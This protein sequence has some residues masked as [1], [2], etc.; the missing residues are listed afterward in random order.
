MA[1]TILQTVVAVLFDMAA[2]YQIFMIYR[3]FFS[4]S[5]KLSARRGLAIGAIVLG[6]I[7][8]NLYFEMAWDVMWAMLLVVL[9]FG[10]RKLWESIL[11]VPAL[12]VYTVVGVIPSIML[13]NVI[14]VTP[15]M[16]IGWGGVKWIDVVAEL[17][18]CALVTFLWRFARKHKISLLLRPL[19]VAGFVLFF[20]FE[21]F[22]L[23]VIAVI[24]AYYV[25]WD[26]LALNGCCIFFFA[27]AMGAYL[28]HLVTLRRVRRLDALVKQ[29]ENYINFQ[30]AYLEKYRNENQNIHA[31]RHDLRGHLQVIRKLQESNQKHKM[32]VYLDSLQSETEQILELEFTGNQVADIVLADQHSRAKEAGIPFVCEGT[33]PW[34]ERLKPMEA[35]SLLSNLLDNAYEAS[36]TEQEPDISV[37]GGMNNNYWTFTVSNHAKQ[38]R[39]VKNNRVRTS[40]KRGDHG[41]GLG[42][43]EQI[44]EKYGGICTFSWEDER[45]SCRIL[46][47]VSGDS[48]MEN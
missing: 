43:V 16:M 33:F 14:T 2:F 17:L 42:I 23:M 29:E 13:Q 30:L 26:K 19:E 44:V 1:M 5:V 46:F 39:D 25:G 18:G 15:F 8:M 38:K 24:R 7:G 27:I 9:L 6:F 21:V 48:K 11:L 22:L 45:F 28:W 47:P 41:L 32:E 12:M 34:L 40:K 36:L 3:L 4:E 10:E 20:F 31:L 37:R 35:C